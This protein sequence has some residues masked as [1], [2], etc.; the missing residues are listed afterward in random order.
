MPTPD[1]SPDDRRLVD[2]LLCR[3]EEAVARGETPRPETICPDRPDLWQAFV[4]RAAQLESMAF[5]DGEERPVVSPGQRLNGRFRLIEPLAAGGHAEVWRAADETLPQDVAVKLIPIGP[6]AAPKRLIE[7]GWRLA[8]LKHPH[9]VRVLDVGIEDGIAFLVQDLVTGETLAERIAS[10]PLPEER[11]LAW[12]SGVAKALQSAHDQP[13]GIIHRDVKPANILID[14]HGNALLAD[15]GI[16]LPIGEAASGTSAGTLPY[17]SPE[18]LD[19]RPLDRRSDVFSLALVLYEALTGTLP[20]SAHD[21]DTIRREMREPLAHRIARLPASRPLPARFLPL[22]ERAL[23]VHPDARPRHARAFCEELALA[24]AGSRPSGRGR[25]LAIAATLAAIAATLVAI[26]VEA[27]NTER[28]RRSELEQRDREQKQVVRQEQDQ[29]EFEGENRR[30]MED[31]QRD[32]DRAMG[33][34]NE[35]QGKISGVR[36]MD[37]AIIEQTRQRDP[38][39]RDREAA[40]GEITAPPQPRPDDESTSGRP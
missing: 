15:F 30:Q 2:S 20:Y 23:A 40:A 11:I 25:R 22:L 28:A 26:V 39:R 33:L 14:G 6:L 8:S 9:I 34:F 12:I 19:G 3:W 32:V 16:A 17:K 38:F 27:V 24:A 10:G 29:R 37:R 35:V 13:A 36:Q 31:V 21:A 1:L 5:L 4:A 7:E 18:Q